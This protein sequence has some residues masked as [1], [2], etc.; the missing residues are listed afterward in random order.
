MAQDPRSRP[1]SDV[2]F[3]VNSY[4]PNFCAV[5]YCAYRVQKC[6][7]D[8][9]NITVIAARNDRSQPLDAMHEGV[10]IMRIETASMKRRNALIG[11]EG[12]KAAALLLIVRAQSALIRL[13]SP[14]TIDRSLVNAYRLQ[15]NAMVPPPRAIVPL[16]FPFE[17]VLAAM[18]YKKD[19]PRVLVVPYL[20][21]DF[22]DSGS[23][24]V[25]KLAR[26]LK[27]PRH[28]RLERRMLIESNFILCMHPLRQH[29]ET[30][31]TKP[32]LAK[33]SYLEH[34]LLFPLERNDFRT[35]DGRALLC[36]TGS[37]LKKVREADHLLVLLNNIQPSFQVRADFFV[38]GNDTHKVR[39]SNL[40]NGVQ[41]VNH[42]YVPKS[43]ADAAVRNADILLNIGEVQGKQVSSKIFEYM[44]TGKPIIHLSY[45]ENDAVLDILA[46]YPLALCLIQDSNLSDQNAR[47]ITKFINENRRKKISYAEVEA[48]YPEARPEVTASLIKNILKNPS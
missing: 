16:V 30:Y 31:F 13:L 27:R 17:A 7:V 40:A 39:T 15:L 20:F 38:M 23:L 25:L 14:V 5:G 42:G 18:E 9:L 19:N 34:P 2:V 32:L 29:L 6:L 33:V 26:W 21:D 41:V 35:E 4:Y 3:L 47:K 37:L 24:H 8:E 44:A 11:V 43:E 36:F 1:L 45:V 10:R 48:I 46:K 28:I 22:V 12:W